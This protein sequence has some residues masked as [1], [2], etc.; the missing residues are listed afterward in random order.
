MTRLYP[1]PTRTNTLFPVTTL[2]RSARGDKVFFDGRTG[3]FVQPEGREIGLVFQSYAL[4]PHMTV[5]ENLDFPL[6]L[7]KISKAERAQRIDEVLGLVEMSDYGARYPQ[8]LSGGQQQRVALA[9]T[10]VYRPSLLLLDAPLSNLDAKL[11]ER[12]RPRLRHPQRRVGVP[13]VSLHPAQTE[14][15][16]A[17]RD[18]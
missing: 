1:R 4:W 3:R 7:R 15:T 17:N 5:R 11:R 9:R 6:K 12:A 14:A 13:P 8:A 10:L 18:N 16:A 2:F